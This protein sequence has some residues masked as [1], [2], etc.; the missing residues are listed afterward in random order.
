MQ[1]MTRMVDIGRWAA[2][3]AVAASPLAWGGHAAHPPPQRR[4]APEP[5]GLTVA[6]RRTDTPV[7]TSLRS[8][9]PAER[10]G[11]RVGDEV[12]AVNG[13]RTHGATAVRRDLKQAPQCRVALDLR[14]AGH[15]VVATVGRCERK[16]GRTGVGKG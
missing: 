14:R 11:I 2:A 9:G 1:G 4:A 5:I 7:I 12:R 3:L 8:G 10:G 16:P 6:D 13:H 15:H